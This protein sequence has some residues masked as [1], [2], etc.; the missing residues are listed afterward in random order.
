MTWTLRLF[1][2]DGVE[3]AWVTAD[4]YEYEI[5]HPDAGWDSL[6][7]SLEGKERGEEA[8]EPTEIH[9]EDFRITIDNSIRHDRTPEDHLSWIRDEVVARS[10]VESATITDE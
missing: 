3:I 4:P 2:D 8:L 9:A 1:D 5:T 7:L 6:R 10:D